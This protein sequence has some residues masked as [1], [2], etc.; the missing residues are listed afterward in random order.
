[1]RTKA[2]AQSDGS[3]AITGQE[4]FHHQGEHDMAENIV[5][6]PW[7]AC[8]TRPLVVRVFLCYRA[9]ILA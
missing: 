7:R 9:E 1:M 5:H 6:L 2:E 8:L 4:N 3:Y